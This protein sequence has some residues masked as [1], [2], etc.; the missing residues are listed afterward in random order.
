MTTGVATRDSCTSS[1]NIKRNLL[2]ELQQEVSGFGSLCATPEISIG[3][4]VR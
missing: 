2:A 1:Q 4:L 3:R